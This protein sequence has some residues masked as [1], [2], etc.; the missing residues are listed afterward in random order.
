[1]DGE[2]AYSPTSAGD[3]L[4]GV[5][6]QSPIRPTPLSEHEGSGKG[7][8]EEAEEEVGKGGKKGRPHRTWGSVTPERMRREDFTSL[9]HPRAPWPVF[10]EDEEKEKE[11][12]ASSSRTTAR[13]PSG[14]AESE[15]RRTSDDTR[16]SG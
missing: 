4:E 15:S 5:E 14:E 1:M 9:K 13:E 16:R 8:Q 11:N 6:I 12:A 10:I 3:G 7:S 2:C